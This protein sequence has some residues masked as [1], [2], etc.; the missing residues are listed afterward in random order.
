MDLTELQT[1]LARKFRGTSLDDVQGI[2]DFSVYKEA[3]SNVLSRIDPYETVR[4]HRLNIYPDVPDY[5]PPSDLKGKKVIDPRPQ[6][7][8]V[9]ED[10]HQTFTKEFD[11][12][13]ELYKV[14][15][16]FIDG[17]KVLRINA[18]GKGSKKVDQTADT[19]E[20]T[21]GGGASGLAVDSVIRLDNSD[22]L[23]ASLG[24]AGGYFEAGVADTMETMDL[25]A[26]EDISSFFRKVYVPSGAS[27]ISSITLLIGSSSTAYWTITGTPHFGSWR[28]GVNLIRFDWSSAS[29]TLAPSA[30]AIDYERL[31]FVTTA[32]VANVRIGPLHSRLAIPYE[33]PYY[34]NNI[35]REE[36]GDWVQDPTDESNDVI[37]EKEAENIFFYECCLIV[38]EDLTLDEEAVKFRKK[39]G[40]D[41]QGDL[42]GGG[43]YGD[44][45]RDKPSEGL[46]PQ[47]RY[48]TFRRRGR[49]S[50]GITRE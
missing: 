11:R 6:D 50:R 10:F 15:V 25:S 8:R 26:H 48:M 41:E 29:E 13:R 19:D 27:S 20:W 39:L 3:A 47:S 24:A 40:V 38:A 34:S 22:T 4:Y 30:S 9:G 33:V 32:A 2:T 37:F 17:S 44:Y 43:L 12:D 14:S 21:V 36:D 45:M 5:S 28:N 1:R 49:T 23:R 42:T 16:E 7:N 35:F 31:T 46:R 18:P